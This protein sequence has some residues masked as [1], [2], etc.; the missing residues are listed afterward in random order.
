MIFRFVFFLRLNGGCQF[1]SV[2]L[3]SL[4][5]GSAG[6]FFYLADAFARE[7]KRVSDFFEGALFWIADAVAHR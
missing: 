5:D 6:D 4:S 7:A 1:G 2:F 3:Q